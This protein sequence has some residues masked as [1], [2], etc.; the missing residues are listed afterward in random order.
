MVHVLVGGDDAPDLRELES[1]LL[2]RTFDLVL[3]IGNAG[4][5]KR[6]AL[7]RIQDQAQV[8]FHDVG[9]ERHRELENVEI[10]VDFH[11]SPASREHG[12]NGRRS[13]G[14]RLLLR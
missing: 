8:Q 5:D 7:A 2:Q 14:G 3:L 10:V 9:S 1:I 11:G 12:T 6:Q 4:I 13:S